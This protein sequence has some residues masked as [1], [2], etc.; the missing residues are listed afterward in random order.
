VSSLADY[1]KLFAPYIPTELVS[2]GA[3]ADILDIASVLPAGFARHSAFLECHLGND[4]PRADFEVCADARLSQRGVLLQ[5]HDQLP[6]TLREHPVWKQVNAF[7]C[8]WVDES[9]PIY[10]GVQDVWLEFDLVQGKPQLFLPSVFWGPVRAYSNSGIEHSNGAVNITDQ[11]VRLLT[12]H[13]PTAGFL[14]MFSRIL[15]ALPR[16]AGVQYIA[17]MLGRNPDKVRVCIERMPRKQLVDY[18]QHLGWKVPADELADVAEWLSDD[19]VTIPFDMDVD[20][21][22]YPRIGI[23]CK[24]E[25]ND[26]RYLEF[27]DILVARGLCTAKKRDGIADYRGTSF[28]FANNEVLG[29]KRR[30]LHFKIVCHP[31]RPVEAKAYLS[32][33][34][35]QSSNSG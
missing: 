27:L 32:A 16:G 35:L 34:V 3:F 23:E 2:P 10:Q 11:I 28:T 22:I 14:S 7:A 4:I 13:A 29:L 9:S 26:P 31:G 5:I 6:V 12:N 20:D 8:Q 21:V 1:L 30:F 18:L 25:E 15:D 19:F 17:V 24:W 33:L